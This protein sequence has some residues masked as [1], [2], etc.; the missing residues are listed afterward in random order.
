[1][2]RRERGGI[3]DFSSDGKKATSSAKS[4]G[5]NYVW[6]RRA[7]SQAACAISS[8]R[9]AAWWTRPDGI[10]QGD[11]NGDGKADVFWRKADGTNYVWHVDGS[12]ISGG[13]IAISSQGLLPGADNTWT[14]VN[15]K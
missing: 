12:T 11:Y 8:Q 2:T 10:R 5:T 6:R 4:D 15:P 3:G 13:V 14:L 7:A 9:P 1:M